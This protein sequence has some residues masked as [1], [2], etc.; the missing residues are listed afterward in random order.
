MNKNMIL[1]SDFA[2]KEY[3]TSETSADLKMLIGGLQSLFQGLLQVVATVKQPLEWLCK[4][5]SV[6]LEKKVSMKQ[7][8]L[9]LETQMAFLM[10]IFPANI[11][12]LLRMASLGWFVFCL[13]RCKKSL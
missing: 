1:S 8:A 2:N 13:I 10:V 7:T 3:R 11:S 12:L 6:V 4:Y 5:Y 9:L